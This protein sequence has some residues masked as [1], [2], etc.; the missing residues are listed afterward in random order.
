MFKNYKPA[1]P[2][3]SMLLSRYQSSLFD[4]F[5]WSINQESFKKSFKRVLMRHN[6][7]TINSIYLKQQVFTDVHLT[8]DNAH[9]HCPPKLPG[10]RCHLSLPQPPPH[11]ILRKSWSAFPP[12]RPHLLNF[13]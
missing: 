6:L 13:K 12:S 8:Q 10:I 3:E 1:D 9:I 7:Y 11:S 4:F 5:S 2:N